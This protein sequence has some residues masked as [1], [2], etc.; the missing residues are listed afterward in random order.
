MFK[1]MNKR[2]DIS[3]SPG[4]RE[5]RS[6]KRIRRGA[7]T[8]VGIIAATSLY[9]SCSNDDSTPKPKSQ[10]VPAVCKNFIPEDDQ[11][12]TTKASPDAHKHGS[13]EQQLP[14]ET[15]TITHEITA[16]E[17]L[18][19]IANCYFSQP[20]TGVESLLAANPDITD[21]SLLNIGQ[22]VQVV[23]NRPI[24]YVSDK[25]S[26]PLLSA[27]TG[28]PADMLAKLNSIDLADDIQLGTTV[29]L[30]VESALATDDKTKILVTHGETLNEIADASNL[31]IG[32]LLRLNP[33]FQNS[34]PPAGSLLLVPSET[35]PTVTTP[36]SPY[37]PPE[38]QLRGFMNEFEWLTKTIQK[39]HDIPGDVLLAQ[40][41]LETGYGESKLAK[42]ANN[43]LGMKAHKG[44]K[45][46]D[47][48][49]GSVYP[50]ETPEELTDEQLESPEFKDAVFV[51]KLEN[52][53]NLVTIVA[54]FRKYATIRD[55]FNDYALKI[56]ENP[57]YAET[58]ANRDNQQKYIEALAEKYATDTGYADS[59]TR[60]IGGIEAVRRSDEQA[61]AQ[62]DPVPEDPERP[63]TPPNIS[64]RIASVELSLKGYEQFKKNLDTSYM[65]IAAQKRAFG[66]KGLSVEQGKLEIITWH[67]TTLYVNEDG[68]DA[69]RP[70]GKADPQR[71]IDSMDG[72]KGPNC[73]GIQFF[74]DRDGKTFQFTD[75]DQRVKHNPPY[76]ERSLGLEIESDLQENVTTD[77]YEEAAYWAAFIIENTDIST[78]GPLEDI[79]G[80]HAEQRAHHPSLDGRSDFPAE[81]STQLRAKLLPLL[82]E[83]GYYN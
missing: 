62:P 23:I 52:G 20:E 81:V 27:Q 17:S 32:S 24:H 80:G 54:D 40:A 58:Y 63:T 3:S 46:N 59:I 8:L 55:N 7:A 48:W 78:K 75:L 30:P 15:L 57:V 49:D 83:L 33:G 73:C 19:A 9:N 34:T 42:E 82:Q 5:S 4:T 35:G 53:N 61:P 2:L 71:L 60:I 11:S 12:E 28:F 76:D 29:F 39:E 25:N 64:E 13:N 50:K 18:G 21:P 37:T 72:R 31:S 66:G 6:S 65:K 10:P 16:G 38:D 43:Y 69:S 56:E 77:Q 74:T 70:S 14:A 1:S 67:F 51:E 45:P 68:S 26:V 22:K 36:E 41:I 47:F 44:D 79:V